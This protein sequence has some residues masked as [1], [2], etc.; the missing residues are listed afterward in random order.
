[1]GLP[2]VLIS[3]LGFGLA[4]PRALKE[5]SDRT[6]VF[7]NTENKRFTERDFLKCIGDKDI[8]IAGTELI[9]RTVL[10]SGKRLKLVSRVGVGVDNIDLLT[11]KE[12]NVKISFTPEATVDS[13]AE[14]TMGLILNLLRQISVSNTNIHKKNWNK[15]M[16]KSL[17]GCAIGIIGAG[18][19]GK[20]LIKLI[21]LVEPLTSV[22]FY[23]PFVKEVKGAFRTS[24]KNIFLICDLISIHVPLNED[25]HLFIGRDQLLSMPP[26]SFVVNTSRGGVL[27]ENDLCFALKNNLAG[28]AI[29][30]FENEPYQGDLCEISN[31]I[32]T[33]HIASFTKETRALMEQQVVEDI[34]NYID[35]KPLLRQYK[36]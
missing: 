8:I 25:T 28:A 15:V 17:S 18:K 26:N 24:F 19:I 33:S 5:L 2:K 11:A 22:Y 36:L 34:L 13:V 21:K 23:D 35:G 14:F 29:D 9:N 31:V 6:E 3:N 4:N 32:L 12:K 30:V 20:K 1:M 27:N 7:M 16:G 10:L